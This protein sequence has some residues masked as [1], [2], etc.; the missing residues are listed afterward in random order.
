M[1]D[2]GLS[3]KRP[4]FDEKTLQNVAFGS[5]LRLGRGGREGYSVVKERFGGVAGRKK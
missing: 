2:M 5:F 1:L 4:F 3:Q